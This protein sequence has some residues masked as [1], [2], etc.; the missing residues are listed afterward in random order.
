MIL[1][2][3]MIRER[4]L[5]ARSPDILISPFLE[6]SVA[7]G[8]SYGLASA[9]YDIRINQDLVVDAKEFALASSVEFFSL[10]SDLDMNV[11]DKSTWAR[12]GISLFNTTAEPGW[13]GYLTLEIVN[14][15]GRAVQLKRGMPIAQVKFN[16]LAA[17]T[18]R[19][20]TGKY[21]NQSNEPVQ[22]KFEF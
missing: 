5:R 14:H 13:R 20:Y 9:G 16:L 15:S 7:H 8:M 3:Q 11:F 10:P 18:E 12:Q 21:Q 6:R 22:A 2:G 1:P 4:C 17:A 19:P